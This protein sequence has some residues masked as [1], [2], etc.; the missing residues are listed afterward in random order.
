M[1]NKLTELN[2]FCATVD[3][4]HRCRENSEKE[5]KQRMDEYNESH[6]HKSVE[7]DKK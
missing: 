6:Q 1:K 2:E 3:I 7:H 5:R 4:E